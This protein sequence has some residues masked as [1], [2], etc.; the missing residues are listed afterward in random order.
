M[1]CPAAD[2]AENQGD[3]A[4]PDEPLTIRS[5]RD[6]ARLRFP[7]GPTRDQSDD[8]SRE[9]PDEKAWNPSS[10]IL[11]EKERDDRRAATNEAKKVGRCK[12]LTQA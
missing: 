12:S 1:R 2:A 3:Y 10:K 11:N 9:S 6:S 4:N 7:A 5:R 8:R